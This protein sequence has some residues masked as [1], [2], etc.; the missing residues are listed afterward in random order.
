MGSIIAVTP[1][2]K[3]P[4]PL[5]YNLGETSLIIT[6]DYGAPDAFELAA[7]TINEAT[8]EVTH[9]PATIVLDHDEI[10]NLYQCLHSLFVKPAC[11]EASGE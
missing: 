6:S 7:P 5:V 4:K 8:Q 11:N 9:T 1:D 10:Y 3:M 2:H